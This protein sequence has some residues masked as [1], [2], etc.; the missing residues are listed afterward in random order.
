MG[1]CSAT[2]QELH[3]FLA[4][5]C[6]P[7]LHSCLAHTRCSVNVSG[8]DEHPIVSLPSLSSGVPQIGLA[9][10]WHM[11]LCFVSATIVL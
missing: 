2:D 5:H 1:V 7:M 8:M 3:L 4:H 9:Q 10:R 11:I 6:L